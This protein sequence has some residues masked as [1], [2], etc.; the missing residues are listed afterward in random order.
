MWNKFGYKGQRPDGHTAI[1]ATRGTQ[2]DAI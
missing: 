2:E 1:N